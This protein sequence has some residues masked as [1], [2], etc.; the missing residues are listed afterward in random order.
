M[1]T[2]N[3]PRLWFAVV[4]AALGAG[5]LVA[6]GS[7]SDAELQAT[8]TCPAGEIADEEETGWRCVPQCPAGMMVDELTHVCVAAPGVPPAFPEVMQAPTPQF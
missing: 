4:G 1:S 3:R 7:P 5:A 8:A 2:I 6:A